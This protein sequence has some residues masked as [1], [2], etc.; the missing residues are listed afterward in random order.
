MCEVYLKPLHI[1]MSVRDLDE[2]M[3]WY[4][5]HLG[6]RAVFSMYIPAHHARI[7]FMR[8]G[9]F[10]IEL[11]RHDDTRPI[12]PERLD[13][14]EDQKTQGTKHIAFLVEDVDSVARRLESEGVEI[15]AAPKVM[16][17]KEAGVREK[18]CFARDCN[19]IAIEFIQRL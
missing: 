14:H 9:D 3:K 17:N 16:E 19:G 15:A 6:F 11:V 5:E 2:S 12:P 1:S 7:A 8:H 18:I 13:P 4:E 10:D